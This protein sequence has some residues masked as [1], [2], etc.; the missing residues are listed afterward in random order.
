MDLLQGLKIQAE[1]LKE[2][3]QLYRPELMKKLRVEVQR[4]NE[5]LILSGVESGYVVTRGG[6]LSCL[7]RKL[8]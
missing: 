1:Q 5:K 8:A 6:D 7:L 2:M 3:D 4:R